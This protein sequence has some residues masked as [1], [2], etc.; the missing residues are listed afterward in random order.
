LVSRSL[1]ELFRREGTTKMQTIEGEVFS[2]QEYMG[3]GR[4]FD[5]ESSLSL[6]AVRGVPITLYSSY[7]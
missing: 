3:Q 7:K 4:V 2:I 5:A 1:A 6:Q